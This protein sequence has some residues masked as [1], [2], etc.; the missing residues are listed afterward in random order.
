MDQF[1]SIRYRN[2]C[3]F[4]YTILVDEE[5]RNFSTHH[6]FS[7]WFIVLSSAPLSATHFVTYFDS[8]KWLH[9]L[10]KRILRLRPVVLRSLCLLIS[11]LLHPRIRR[12][13]S[14]AQTL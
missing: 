8:H 6:F 13:P 2:R 11:Q 7:P 10:C 4:N 1:I 3:L 12:I 14:L 9:P 5:G